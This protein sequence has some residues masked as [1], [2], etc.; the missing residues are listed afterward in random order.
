V[1]PLASEAAAEEVKKGSEDYLKLALA[2]QAV[3]DRVLAEMVLASHPEKSWDDILPELKSLNLT[4]ASLDEIAAHIKSPQPL[5]AL[6]GQLNSDFARPLLVQCYRIALSD[7]VIA[8]AEQRVIEAIANKFRIP[9][10]PVEEAVKSEMRS[11]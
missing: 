3:M 5:Q 1:S 2:Q 11:R 8:P 6:L 4:P 10:G 7:G 9:V